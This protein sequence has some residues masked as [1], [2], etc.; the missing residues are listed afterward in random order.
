MYVGRIVVVGRTGE[1]AGK[2]SSRSFPNRRAEVRGSDIMV[3]SIDPKDLARNPYIAYNCI[4]TKRRRGC[5]RQRRR[6][7]EAARDDRRVRN[8][9]YWMPAEAGIKC[10]ASASETPDG[11]RPGVYIQICNMDYKSLEGSL[12]DSITPHT[13]IVDSPLRCLL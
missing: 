2:V 5:G 10:I 9:G 8:L 1:R 6:A 7:L 13:Q 3:S 11:R 4:K 12:A